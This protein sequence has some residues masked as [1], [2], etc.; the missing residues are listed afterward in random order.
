MKN[1][2]TFSFKFPLKSNDPI[3]IK[4][5]FSI[6]LYLQSA[7][8]KVFQIIYTAWV[9]I[10]FV[11]G[12]FLALP[13]VVIPI[14]ISEKLG[15]ISFLATRI[16]VYFFAT[17]SLIFFKTHNREIIDKKKSYIFV[18]NHTSFMD[19]PAIA[20]STPIQLRALGK[21]ELSK[22]PVFGFITS[23][24]AVWVDRSDPESRKKSLA[25]L[26]KTLDNGISILVAPEGTRNNSG[27]PLL[28]FFNGPFRLAIETG[29]PIL[30]LVIHDAKKV[31]PKG[32]LGVKPGTI[33]SYFLSPV[34][35]GEMSEENLPE[36]KERVFQLMKE[37]VEALDEL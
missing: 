27:D 7:L 14:L 31:M 28:P 10:L 23:R 3:H 2:I 30:P 16:W 33:H 21:K 32:Q 11:T 17:P 12:M 24:V 26:I 34:E 5:L 29:T 36:L 6:I 8:K 37:K 35:T 18:I 1:H 4:K 13:F 15:G 19:A 9:A 22:I 25:R 20:M